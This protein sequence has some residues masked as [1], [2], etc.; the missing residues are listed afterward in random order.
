MFI[1]TD[2]FG[3]LYEGDNN[4]CNKCLDKKICSKIKNME[5]IGKDKVLIQCERVS[6]EK[7]DIINYLKLKN[8]YLFMK[9]NKNFATVVFPQASLATEFRLNINFRGLLQNKFFENIYW[10]TGIGYC[11]I[12]SM[13]NINN[14]SNIVMY[15][16]LLRNIKGKNEK[17]L[18]GY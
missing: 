2:C 7:S 5:T 9:I 18:F 4:V 13:K 17:L 8:K 10:R 3:F 11:K 15:V 14:V 16:F 6:T 1:I 12:Y